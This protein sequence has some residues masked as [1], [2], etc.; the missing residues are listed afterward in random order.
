MQRRK[1]YGLAFLMVLI[2]ALAGFLWA[3]DRLEE[4]QP[5]QL[6]V[7]QSVQQVVDE[8][9][10]F[11][12][13]PRIAPAAAPAVQ[14]TPTAPVR[15]P[16]PVI[17]EGIEPSAP[18]ILPAVETTPPPATAAVTATPAAPAPAAPQ[19]PAEQ[20]YP[21]APVGAVRHT[22]GDCAG[23]SILGSVRDAG[24]N[25]LAGVRLWRYDQ[26]GNEQV[27]E[28]KAGDADRGQYDFPLGDTT[29]VHYVQV[30][31]AGGVIISPVV[32]IQHRQGEAPDAQ[33][34][35]LDWQQR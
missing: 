27:V 5:P 7:A 30:I 28:S 25:L 35:W 9:D 12:L 11:S 18:A 19:L 24:G 1:H 32:E 6:A 2:A 29:N 17:V 8:I 23:A 20:A 26:W 31:D 14:P 16:Q 15:T 10:I 3:R 33:C 13:L 34:H 22:S 4:F 21:F